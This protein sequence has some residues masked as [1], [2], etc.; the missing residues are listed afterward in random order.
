M[1]AIT[2][3]ERIILIDALR[4]FALLGIL[5]VNWMII[6]WPQIWA[7]MLHTE[8]WSSAIDKVA[9]WAV[10]YFFEYK[11]FSLFSFLFGI[12]FTVQFFKAEK[13]KTP[14][15]S[16]YLRRQFV[17][18]LIGALHALLFWPGDFLVLY[19]MQ[20]VLLLLFRN[21]KTK[22]ILISSVI[23]FLIPFLLTLGFYL[24][25]SNDA[26]MMT[27]LQ[28]E[29]T[30]TITP[31]LTQHNERSYAIYP[32]GNFS[33][34]FSMRMDDT[35]RF[36]KSLPFWW[37]N[38]FAMF[39]LGLYAGK[40][41]FFQ[42]MDEMKDTLK[43]IFLISGITGI[44]GNIIFVW[45]Y[46]NQNLFIPN[47]YNVIYSMFHIISVPT[48]TLFYITGFYFISKTLNGKKLIT[49]LAPMG[50]IALTN[51]V[52]QSIIC[53]F[54]L[55]G[56]GLGLYGSISPSIGL[57]FSMGI[58]LFQLVVSNWYVKRFSYGPLEYIWR[59]VIYKKYS[60]T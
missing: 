37:W 28:N 53:N 43:K 9:I 12:G 11:F 48:M 2:K 55:F 15:V 30:N 56:F 21:A 54:I 46:H 39:L 35:M 49:L 58:W 38:S 1:Q 45:A 22:T 57:L 5:M 8:I 24:A 27:Q 7:D 51:Y 33:Q 31:D 60:N 25:A 14:F 4:G 36:Y 23:I 18:F 3:T 20:G 16:Y 40:E 6:S 47:M 52:M 34:I 19:S 32:V 44:G 13:E 42:R 10:H 26:G 41:K 17:L 29:Y 50:K 59:S